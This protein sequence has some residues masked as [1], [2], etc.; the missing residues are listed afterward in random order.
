MYK[1][2][3]D[4]IAAV[5]YKLSATEIRTKMN[6]LK[7]WYRRQADRAGTSRRSEQRDGKGQP[8]S[9][10]YTTHAVSLCHSIQTA[11]Q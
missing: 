9:R 3:V 4:L 5:N 7:L 2:C 8:Y 6:N 10:S 1:K 11:N